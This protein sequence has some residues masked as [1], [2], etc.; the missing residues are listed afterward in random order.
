MLKVMIFNGSPRKKWNT[1]LMLES[2]LNGIKTSGEVEAKWVDLYDYNYKGCRSCFACKLKGGKS[3]GRCAIQD[4][5][6]PILEEAAISDILLFGTPIYFQ[7]ITG[8]MQSFLER[9]MF[10]FSCYDTEH[11]SLWPKKTVCGVVYTM[12]ATADILN[13]DPFD[14][15]KGLFKTQNYFLTRFFG[16]PEVYYCQDTY[17]F[18]NYDNY[19]APKWDKEAKKKR[20]E[21]VFPH[22]L[23][24]A[25]QM[26]VKLANKI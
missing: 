12:N 16:E 13:T 4:E 19:Y 17:Q 8:E 1:A 2:I 3:Y 9:L 25:F 21:E 23:Q 18:A 24:A 14:G 6:T 5:I 11:P 26:G 7:N 20:R 22:D 10:P 15:V